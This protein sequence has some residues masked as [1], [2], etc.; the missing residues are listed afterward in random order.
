MQEA[1]R[2]IGVILPQALVTDPFHGGIVNLP[3]IFI[4]FAL[5]AIL[6]IGVKESAR[7]NK[8]VVFI[9]LAVIVLFIFIGS[10]HFDSANWHPFLPFGKQGI[11]NGAGLIFFAYIGFDAVST[12]ARRSH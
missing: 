2:A 9:K 6:S 12:A 5:A 1:L 8:V 10:F 4:I 7:F 11:V 3:A